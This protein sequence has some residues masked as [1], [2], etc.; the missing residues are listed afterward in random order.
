MSAALRPRTQSEGTRLVIL[1]HTK[2]RDF[3]AMHIKTLVEKRLAVLTDWCSDEPPTEATFEQLKELVNVY[4]DDLPTKHPRNYVEV[5]LSFNQ[6]PE[7][8]YMMVTSEV[9][10]RTDSV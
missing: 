5:K 3:E 9:K 10:K 8:P 7:K 2:V 1:V 4:L 6:E